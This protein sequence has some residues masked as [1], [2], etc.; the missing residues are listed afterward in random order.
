MSC[1]PKVLLSVRCVL[2][3]VSRTV[4]PPKATPRSV[5]SLTLYGGSDGATDKPL[6]S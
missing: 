6:G 3:T 1:A 2:L 5:N 4:P